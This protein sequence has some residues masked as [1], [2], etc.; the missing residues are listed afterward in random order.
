MNTKLE[1]IIIALALNLTRAKSDWSEAEALLDKAPDGKRKAGKLEVGSS[2]VAPHG[3]DV[4]TEAGKKKA[5]GFA[6]A[7]KLL[8]SADILGL[9][10]E[11]RAALEEFRLAKKAEAKK[12][13]ASK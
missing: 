8:N 5:K 2:R 7:A 4:S 1:N 3:L 11:A 10:N 9:D 13:E 6:D 12:S